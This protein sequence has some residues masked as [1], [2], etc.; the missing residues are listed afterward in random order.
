ERAGGGGPGAYEREADRDGRTAAPTGHRHRA[1]GEGGRDHSDRERSV[2]GAEQALEPEDGEEERRVL[3]VVRGGEARERD[4]RR[5]RE[6]RDRDEREH[7]P[8]RP[9][10]RDVQP[11]RRRSK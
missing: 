1:E 5:Q 10:A 3:L 8:A 4:A 2:G 9:A 7:E 6:H 11:E